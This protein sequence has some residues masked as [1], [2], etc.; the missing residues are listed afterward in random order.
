MKKDSVI[1]NISRGSLINEDDLIYALKN[2]LIAGAALDVFANEPLNKNS[3]F[4]NYDNVILYP[5]SASTTYGENQKII[6]LFKKNIKLFIKNKPLIN[7]F[8]KQNSY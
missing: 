1:I 8:N 5:H 4:W 7:Q 2:K 6:N 3:V